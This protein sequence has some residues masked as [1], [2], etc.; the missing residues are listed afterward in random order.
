MAPQ[1][2]RPGEVAPRGVQTL[3]CCQSCGLVLYASR[4][5]QKYCCAK[6]RAEAWRQSREGEAAQKA[7]RMRADLLELQRRLDAILADL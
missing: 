6:C 7:G 3:L 1:D 4:P 5:N 2:D